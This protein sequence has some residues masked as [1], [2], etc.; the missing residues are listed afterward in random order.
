[1]NVS[2]A[3]GSRGSAG[4]NSSRAITGGMEYTYESMVEL[5]APEYSP[6]NVTSERVIDASSN[7]PVYQYTRLS[8]Q[9]GGVT[10]TTKY[11]TA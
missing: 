10:I 3:D 2:S 6:V 1:M 8:Y 4:P 11:C 9:S 7:P 5:Y